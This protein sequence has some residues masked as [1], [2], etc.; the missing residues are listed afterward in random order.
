VGCTAPIRLVLAESFTITGLT[1]SISVSPPTIE[2]TAGARIDNSADFF[3]V[4]ARRWYVKIRPLSNWVSANPPDNQSH[5]PRMAGVMANSSRVNFCPT[6]IFHTAQG[7]RMRKPRARNVSVFGGCLAY[8]P[9][10]YPEN[11]MESRLF[12][13][14]VTVLSTDGSH[15]ETFSAGERVKNVK[16]I[17]RRVMFEPVNTHRVAGTYAMDWSQ[18][19][20]NTTMVNEAVASA[21]HNLQQAPESIRTVSAPAVRFNEEA[22]LPSA[23]GPRQDSGYGSRKAMSKPCSRRDYLFSRWNAAS[24][25]LGE[26][27]GM[28][29]RAIREGNLDFSQ[30]DSRIQEARDEERLAQREHDRHVAIHRCDD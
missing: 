3:Y 29:I 6:A 17:G 26:L 25:A 8:I 15:S 18:F 30:W 21:A 22:T 23:G 16:R 19:E 7:R 4:V 27:A 13:R 20:L 24:G 9:R 1:R 10:E 14:P 12:D 28:K 5:P 11:L 2:R